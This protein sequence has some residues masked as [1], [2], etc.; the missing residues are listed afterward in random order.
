MSTPGLTGT[1]EQVGS[2]DTI[3]RVDDRLTA[4]EAELSHSTAA[5]EAMSG[6]IDQV[7]ASSCYLRLSCPLPTPTLPPGPSQ[8][9]VWVSYKLLLHRLS[10]IAFD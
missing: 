3:A 2:R 6:I 10:N 8:R 4:L 9:E 7:Q 5:N 1:A